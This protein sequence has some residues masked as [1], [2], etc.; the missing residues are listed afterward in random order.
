MKEYKITAL[1]ATDAATLTG[2]CTEAAT[3]V[4]QNCEFNPR[5]PNALQRTTNI[6]MK[7][8]KAHMLGLIPAEDLYVD[9]PAWLAKPAYKVERWQSE[10]SY[11][12]TEVGKTPRKVPA[13]LL[14]SMWTPADEIPALLNYELIGAQEF[15]ICDMYGDL[16]TAGGSS[17]C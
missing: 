3:E 1:Y 11:W 17:K 6:L 4:L 7:Q 2:L 16:I 10:Q 13:F 9:L 5:K 14:G 12:I 8:C 15:E